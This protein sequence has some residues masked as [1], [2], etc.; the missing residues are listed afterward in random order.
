MLHFV[1]AQASR[2]Q[3]RCSSHCWHRSIDVN[4][5]LT[6][7]TPPAQSDAA[8]AEDSAT[9][10][11]GDD[12]VPLDWCRHCSR[13][14][15]LMQ[16]QEEDWPEHEPDEFTNRCFMGSA[17]TSRW[18]SSVRATLTSAS[19][20]GVGDEHV[21]HSIHCVFRTVAS[22][23]R[24]ARVRS[25]SRRSPRCGSYSYKNSSEQ[26]PRL[27]MRFGTSGSLSGLKSLQKEAVPTRFEPF[28]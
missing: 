17:S 11:V 15:N 26:Q 8:S 6:T 21:H 19:S 24:S 28:R 27:V 18:R 10:G 4:G 3:E 9:V 16:S 1:L 25:W 23:G 22:R 2:V 14:F 5:H 13:T 7:R 20:S 12:S